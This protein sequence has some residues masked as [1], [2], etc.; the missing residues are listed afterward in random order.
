M[1]VYVCIHNK[2]TQYTYIYNVNK[3]FYF[4]CDSSFD[5]TNIYIYIYIYI[6]TYTLCACIRAGHMALVSS[7]YTA[8]CDPSR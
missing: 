7:R 1:C 6:Y 4:G 3:S 2:Y 5:S 8:D